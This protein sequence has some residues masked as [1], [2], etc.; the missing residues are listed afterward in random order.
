[1]TELHDRQI[2]LNIHLDSVDVVVV[3]VRTSAWL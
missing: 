1:M 3:V 2:T